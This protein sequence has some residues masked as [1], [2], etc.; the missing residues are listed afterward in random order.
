MV[1]PI[2]KK[3]NEDIVGKII[4]DELSSAIA[5]NISKKQDRLNKLIEIAKKMIELLPA[6]E[7]KKVASKLTSRSSDDS[8]FEAA[9]AD[10]MRAFDGIKKTFGVSDGPAAT[11]NGEG[12]P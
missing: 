11:K 12:K 4:V 9:Y 1:S 5:D 7:A 6:H 3:R 10:L 8:E 2:N